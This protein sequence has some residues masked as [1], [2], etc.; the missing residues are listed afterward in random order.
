[1]QV[2]FTPFHVEHLSVL[3]PHKT[4][5]G[6]YARLLERDGLVLASRSMAITAWAGSRCVGAG[7]V[8]HVWPGRAEAWGI[9]G[10]RVGPLTVPVVRK[11]RDIIMT[12]P[13]R[14]LEMSVKT[15]NIQGNRL[16]TMVGF[17]PPEATLRA[18]HPDG[19]DMYMYARIER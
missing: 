10:D 1:M 5:A 13:V 9:F 17:G 12:Y 18:Y 4:Q 2:T 15:H 8:F 11:I 6:E 14:R 16:A 3:T 19:S 7:G